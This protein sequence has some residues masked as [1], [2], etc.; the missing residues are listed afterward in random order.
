MGFSQI[1][2]HSILTIPENKPDI[3][4]I[5][6]VSATPKIKNTENMHRKLLFSGCID[7]CVD[8]LACTADKA[9]VIYFWRTELPFNGLLFHRVARE[10]F[11]ASI[12]TKI[13]FCK[14]EIITPRTLSALFVL[15][16]SK[17]KFSRLPHHMKK[18]SLK[19][20]QDHATYSNDLCDSK[21]N[22]TKCKTMTLPCKDS[23]GEWDSLK[24][25]EKS[26]CPPVVI[27]PKCQPCTSAP[28]AAPE[29]C[30]TPQQCNCSSFPKK[31]NGQSHDSDYMQTSSKTGTSYTTYHS[32]Y[33]KPQSGDPILPEGYHAPTYVQPYTRIENSHGIAF[34]YHY[35]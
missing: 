2:I 35:E 32:G 18:Y 11:S 4:S 15:K 16:L 5:L 21:P 8:Y 12:Q 6:R 27:E 23:S 29:T 26:H 31:M 25:Q 1:S 3:N 22:Q 28:P 20:K 13:I 19:L 14:N 33:S 7:I 34:G 10:C 30:N 24:T 9:E 17:V